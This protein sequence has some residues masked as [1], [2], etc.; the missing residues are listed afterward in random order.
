MIRKVVVAVFGK[1]FAS[2]VLAAILHIFFCAMVKIA[3]K[4]S[5][6]PTLRGFYL[7]FLAAWVT[8]SFSPILKAAD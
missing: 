6:I 7:I 4:P 8:I 5:Y 3:I 1:I 2:A